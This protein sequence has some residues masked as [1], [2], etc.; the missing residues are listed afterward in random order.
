MWEARV[1]GDLSAVVFKDVFPRLVRALSEHD[2]Q[3]PVPLT[4]A[5]LEEVRVAALT[6]LYRLLFV[7][8]AEDRNL[9]PVRDRRYDDYALRQIRL[10]VR[11]AGSHVGS[12][13]MGPGRPCF[14]MLSG[15]DAWQGSGSTRSK[16]QEN[17]ECPLKS[18]KP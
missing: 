6:L 15:Y 9:L 7:L 13:P 1:A 11:R 14:S 12:L 2:P 4:G 17:L 5:Y 3:A 8:Y 10:D 18:K 16:I